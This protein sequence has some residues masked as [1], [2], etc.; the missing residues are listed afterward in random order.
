MNL[1]IESHN[2]VNMEKPRRYQEAEDKEMT[3]SVCLDVFKEFKEP[4]KLPCGHIYCKRCLEGLILHSSGAL[5]TCPTCRNKTEVP[6]K[7]VS[8]FPAA[9]LEVRTIN[10]QGAVVD[11]KEK[12][13]VGQEGYVII[14]LQVATAGKGFQLETSKL[15]AELLPVLCSDLGIRGR[16]ES[17]SLNQ[18]KVTVTPRIRGKHKV[19]IRVDGAHIMNSPFMIMVTMPPTWLTE[20]VCTLV[21]GLE[22]LTSVIYSKGKVLTTEAMGDKVTKIDVH[23]LGHRLKN[24][25]PLQ[26]A[27]RQILLHGLNEASGLACDLEDNLYVSVAHEVQKFS[28]DGRH[29]K[30]VGCFGTG[31]AEFMNPS[32]LGINC[33]GELYVCDSHNHRLQVFDLELNFKRSFGSQGKAAGHFCYPNNIAFNSNGQ[34]HIADSMNNRIECFSPK[35]CYL[36]TIKHKNLSTP[37]GLLIHDDHIYVTDYHNHRVMV[38]NPAGD[39][40]TT[41]GSE[42]V[43]FPEGIAVDEDGFLYVTTDHSK[44]VV[45]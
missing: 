31:P 20:P 34:I 32:G 33:E 17:I 13:M 41:F 21:S 4:K 2:K 25:V 5:L 28:K 44:I 6:N 22:Q 23:N 11:T 15:E 19:I 3:C 1:L 38:M 45:F 42:H 36:H 18:I 12:L 39:F 29:I 24:S 8:N 27:D 9:V 26:A 40:V 16:I 30:T 43:K 37:T 14:D 10:I 7:D 35:E